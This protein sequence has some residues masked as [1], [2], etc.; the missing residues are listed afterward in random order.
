MAEKIKINLYGMDEVYF[1]SCK[2]PVTTTKKMI[3]YI[4]QNMVN[5]NAMDEILK[6]IAEKINVDKDV[7]WKVFWDIIEDICESD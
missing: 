1:I 7:L 5:S 4:L 6:D 2:H 3:A